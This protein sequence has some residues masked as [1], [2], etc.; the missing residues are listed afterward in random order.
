MLHQLFEFHEEVHQNYEQFHYFKGCNLL[1]ND[2]I[3]T[4][5]FFPGNSI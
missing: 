2:L 5:F 4:F 3:L 1:F